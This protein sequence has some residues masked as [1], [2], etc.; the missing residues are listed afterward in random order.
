MKK[1]PSAKLATK[2]EAMGVDMM[3]QVGTMVFNVLSSDRHEIFIG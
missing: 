3:N 1:A 2:Y